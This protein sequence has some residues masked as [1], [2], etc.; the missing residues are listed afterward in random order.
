MRN[1]KLVLF[2]FLLKD[3]LPYRRKGKTSIRWLLQPAQSLKTA[4]DVYFSFAI[5]AAH[6]HTYVFTKQSSPI[7]Q[8]FSSSWYFH[9]TSANKL[10]AKTEHHSKARCSQQSQHFQTKS[11]LQFPFFFKHSPAHLR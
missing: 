11:T 4:K 2:T 6:T 10:L 5:D 9:L 7:T 8:E 1:P 3:A